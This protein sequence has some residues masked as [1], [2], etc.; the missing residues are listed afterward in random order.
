MDNHMSW[1]QHSNVELNIALISNCVAVRPLLW[2]N[3]GHLEEIQEEFGPSFD[4][5]VGSELLY[6]NEQA[7]AEGLVDTLRAVN[8]PQLSCW[9]AKSDDLE[10]RNF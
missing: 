10:S 4:L 7:F 6:N 9:G 2:G 8:A 1:L 5:V 3:S